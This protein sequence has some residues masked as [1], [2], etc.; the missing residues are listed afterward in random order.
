[1]PAVAFDPARK[2]RLETRVD[3][4]RA[5]KEHLNGQVAG[6]ALI[7]WD[8]RGDVTTSLSTYNGPIARSMVPTFVHDVLIRHDAVVTSRRAK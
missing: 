7:S 5:V 8:A 1:M 4:V 2:K 6:Y 3:L